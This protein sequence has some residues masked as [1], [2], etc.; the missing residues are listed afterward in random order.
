MF[1]VSALHIEHTGKGNFATHC[2]CW[3]LNHDL[4]DVP[5]IV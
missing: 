5:C 2:H 3:E 1:T 4:W